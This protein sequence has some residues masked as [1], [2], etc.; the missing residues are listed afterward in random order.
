M[1]I[2]TGADGQVSGYVSTGLIY[3]PSGVESIYIK[4]CVFD[5]SVYS[6]MNFGSKDTMGVPSTYGMRGDGS[7]GMTLDYFFTVETIA[8]DCIKLTLNS[9]ALHYGLHNRYYRL[10]VKGSGADLVVIHE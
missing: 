8:E 7:S 2:T 10:T 3:L 1:Y 6:R 9:N 4:G 5:T